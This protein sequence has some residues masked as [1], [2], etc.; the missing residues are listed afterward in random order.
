MEL[1][2][3][4]DPANHMAYSEGYLRDVIESPLARLLD[5]SFCLG[6]C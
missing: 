5:S 4:I 1:D 6:N 2:D 3:A